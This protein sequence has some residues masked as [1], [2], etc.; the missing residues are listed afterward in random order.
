VIEVQV[1]SDGR[2]LEMGGPQVCQN[3]RQP[4]DMIV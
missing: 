3:V 4:V 2:G 1:G